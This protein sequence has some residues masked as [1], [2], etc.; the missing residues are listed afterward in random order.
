MH[1]TG[2]YIIKNHKPVKEHSPIND[3]P[4]HLNEIPIIESK[5]SIIQSLIQI[6]YGKQRANNLYNKYK[7]S[8][9]LEELQNYIK[10]ELSNK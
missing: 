4:V 9:N 6:G 2:P 1:P 3:S 5:D 10:R 8:N 7:N